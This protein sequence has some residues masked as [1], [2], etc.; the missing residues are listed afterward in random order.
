MALGACDFA[1]LERSGTD[2]FVFVG[3]CPRTIRG[4]AIKEYLLHYLFAPLSIKTQRI[5]QDAIYSS[6]LKHNYFTVDGRVPLALPVRFPG[7]S[8]ARAKLAAPR[9]GNT[10]LFQPALFQPADRRAVQGYEAD[11]MHAPHHVRATDDLEWGNARRVVWT[12]AG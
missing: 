10:F 5:D 8:R 12:L 3:R 6:P 9:H 2:C 7:S 4:S 1:S 11:L